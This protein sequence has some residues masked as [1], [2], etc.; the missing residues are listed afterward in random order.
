[1]PDF[2]NSDKAAGSKSSQTYIVATAFLSLFA[3]VGFAYYGLPFFY[4]FFVHDNGWSRTQV[5]SGNAIGKLIV[6]PLFGFIAGWLIDRYGPRRLMMSGALMMGTALIGLSFSTS[7]W[8]FYLFYIFNAL[9]YVCGGP[10][11]CQ[12]LISRWFDKNRGKAMGIAYLGIGTGGAVVPILSA[13]LV[14]SFG[15]R[16]ALLTLGVLIVIIAFPL[17][18]FIRDNSDA[19]RAEKADP[20]KNAEEN[21]PISSILKNPYFYLLAFGS[22]CSIGAV[23]GAGQHLKLYL[24]DLDFSQAHAAKVISLMLIASLSGRILMG[25]LAD[26]LARKYVMIL[27]YL[28]VG[29]SIP[30]LLMPEFP[31]RVYIFACTFG[32]GLGGDYM[33]IPLMAGDIFGVKALGRTMGI[34]LVADGASEA[35]FPMLVGYLYD[36]FGSYTIGF[37]VLIGVALTGALI[38]S[39]LPKTGN[40]H[41]SAIRK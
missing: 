34:I 15:W 22:M 13:N 18:Y 29:L 32:I 33:I 31:G 41:T 14:N 8:T 26:L 12:V 28:I 25:W 7:I 9:G 11:P 19:D 16:I 27:I 4:D 10:L 2:L 38:V 35:L 39:F 21:V 36:K 24:R 6:A 1:M 17:S 40:I 23:G 5:T 30:L 20:I 37:L 3:I